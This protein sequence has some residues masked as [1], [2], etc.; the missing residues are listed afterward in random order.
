MLPSGKT[1][2]VRTITTLDGDLAEAAAG[3]SVV[4][5]LEDAID[6]S[7]G[8]IIVRRQAT[9]ADRHATR[10]HPLLDE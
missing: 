1:S 9:S 8:D 2:R 4:L 7:R 5:S 10:V 3:D 6:I